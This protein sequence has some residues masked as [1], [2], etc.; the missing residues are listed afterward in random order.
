MSRARC[1]TL[2]AL[3]IVGTAL[4]RLLMAAELGL[5]IDE[6]YMVAAGRTLHL[7]YFDHPPLSW[8]LSRGAALLAGS[9]RPLVVRLP[10]VA[11]FALSTWLVYRLGALAASPPAGLWA[12]VALNL[13]PALGITTGLWVLPDGPLD[14]ALL[15]AGYCLMRALPGEDTDWG[16][17][18][19]AGAGA[20]LALLSKYSAV[21]TLAGALLYLAS[22]PLHRR[23]LA[24]PQPWVAAAL[25]GRAVRAGAGVE[26][27]P[28]VGQL[29]LPGGPGGGARPEPRRPAAGAGRRG[30]LF[31]AVDLGRA[32]FRPGARPASGTSGLAKLAAVLP[33]AA[34]DRA[35]R[36]GGAVVAPGTAA[37][38]GAGVSV[39][40]PSARRRTGPPRRD[41]PRAL[42]R[43]ATAT[44]ALLA[45]GLAV[46]AAES[47]WHWL[48]A[49]APGFRPWIAGA[50][51][52]A[53]RAPTCKRAACCA[54]PVRRS[55][56]RRG[57]SP[58][59]WTIALGGDRPVLCL[60]T[61][62]GEYNYAPGPATRLG[63]D[64]LL[65]GPGL[66]A[67]RV[68]ASYGRLFDSIDELPPA[69]L[70][71]PAR[72][73]AAIP[74]FLGHHLRHLAVN[75]RRKGQANIPALPWRYLVAS[76]PA[77]H[78]MTKSLVRY[79]TR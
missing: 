57:G 69:E 44:A 2:L 8:W 18:L 25:A 41:P 39:C 37:L 10:F 22:S 32:D 31:A 55:P 62:G 63:E 53:V 14:C 65:L 58:A 48:G 36:R 12:A 70:A 50:R 3:L 64:V 19:G 38:G 35:V 79:G 42:A 60:N 49:V 21:L 29:R 73:A 23:W 72:P 1:L 26:R 46:S 66:D 71:F 68:K 13:A 74:M 75:Q 5:G 47:R 4:L 20:G 61:D 67:A 78:M 9:E 59:S 76:R 43:A 56:A 28:W 34:A 40:L 77:H 7:S 54:G 27:H 11:L 17:W 51:L 45:F 6:T 16:W 30:A 24:R 33:G 52:D 15:G